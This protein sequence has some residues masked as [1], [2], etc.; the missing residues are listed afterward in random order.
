SQYENL[1]K[2]SPYAAWIAA[3]GYRPNHFTIFINKLKSID[4]IETLNKIIKEAGYK[5]NDAGGEIKGSEEV[6]L[7]QSST[8]AM[9]SD[10]EFS[11]GF[12]S[13]PVS[14]YEFASRFP[15]ESGELY[16]GFVAKSADKI[17]ESTDKGQ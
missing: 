12:K 8:L 13:I 9:N 15:D 11:D 14:Y 10:I 4:T 17:F 5:L 2:M 1:F 7:K 6:C 16:Q 3:L